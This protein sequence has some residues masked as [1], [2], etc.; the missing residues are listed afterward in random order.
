MPTWVRCCHMGAAAWAFGGAPYGATKRVR[1]VRA[2]MGAAVAASWAAG[3]ALYGATNFCWLVCRDGRGAAMWALPFG[4]SV[5]LPH[6]ST[7]RVGGM[8]KWL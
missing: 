1:G 2:D 5:W 8:P 6:G 7:E 4:P 3:G